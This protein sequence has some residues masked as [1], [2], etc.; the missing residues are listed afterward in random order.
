MKCQVK[1]VNQWNRWEHSGWEYSEGEF[2]WEEFSSG[3]LMSRNFRV[4][5]F[6]GEN[7]PRTPISKVKSFLESRFDVQ[8]KCLHKSGTIAQLVRFA[9]LLKIGEKLLNYRKCQKNKLLRRLRQVM[10]KNLFAQTMPNKI[11]V[12]QERNSVKLDRTR[13]LLHLLLHTFKLLL[14]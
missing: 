8:K 6:P 7:F 1:Q 3:S 9:F 5:I 13:K 4:G 12:T 14:P 2:S 11:F 10:T